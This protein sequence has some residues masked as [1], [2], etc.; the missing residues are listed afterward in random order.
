MT[1]ERLVRLDRLTSGIFRVVSVRGLFH[2]YSATPRLPVPA[3]TTPFASVAS[4][5]GR[6]QD[7]QP[8][9]EADRLGLQFDRPLFL[10]AIKLLLQLA[11]PA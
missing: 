8:V 10:A 2:E 7:R 3:I 1:A 11:N 6:S 9:L 5:P 4:E